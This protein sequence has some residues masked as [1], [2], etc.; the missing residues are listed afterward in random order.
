MREV[1][2]YKLA[3]WYNGCLMFTAHAMVDMPSAL[4]MESWH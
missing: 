3:L 2:K 4:C 1:S